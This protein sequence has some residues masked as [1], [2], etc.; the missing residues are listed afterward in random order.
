MT[1][2]RKTTMIVAAVLAI[3]LTLLFWQVM[4]GFSATLNTFEGLSVSAPTTTLHVGESTRLT[5]RRKRGLFFYRKLQRPDTTTYFT[6]SESELV[7]EPD[8]RVTCVGTKGRTKDEIWVSAENGRDTGHISF[9]L[10]LAGPGPTLDFVAADIS[11]PATIPD[12]FVRYAPCCSGDPIVMTEGQTI[13]YKLVRHGTPSDDLTTKGIYTVFFGSGVPNDARPSV[14]TG[15]HDYVSSRNFH[16]D[17]QYGT[18][19]A[20]PSIGRDNRDSA[21]VFARYG[22]LVGWKYIVITHGEED[23]RDGHL[24]LHPE[25]R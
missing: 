2:R 22:N 7:V 6:V 4:T 17:S 21:V 23:G 18:I 12:Y 25:D 20:P 11:K 1:K 24:R 8:G 15:G 3:G 19:S 10:L 5:V 9:D 16:V 14:I 13:N